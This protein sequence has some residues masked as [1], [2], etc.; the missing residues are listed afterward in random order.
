MLH[1][2]RANLFE[3]SIN[4]SG[5][6]QAK[7]YVDGYLSILHG[8]GLVLECFTLDQQT[9]WIVKCKVLQKESSLVYLISYLL[10]K[11]SNG[12]IKTV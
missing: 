3:K 9:H 1:V 10:H 12:F 8:S 2:I 4:N 7:I 6:I 5:A 11:C